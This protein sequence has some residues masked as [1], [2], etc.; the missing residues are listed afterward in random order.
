MINICLLKNNQ[1]LHQFRSLFYSVVLILIF[2]QCTTFKKETQL[3]EKPNI[4][5]IAVDDL[6]P[7]LN[8]FGEDHM[9]SPNIDQLAQE[10]VIFTRAYCN[11]P[12][13]GASRA[14]LL[15]GTRPTRNRFI[16]Y[17]SSAEEE[18]SEAVTLPE[19][20]RD[21]GYYTISNGKIFH[22]TTDSKDSWDEIWFPKSN[23]GEV[24]NYL[25]PENVSI[26]ATGKR[27]Y[28]YEKAYVNDSAYF[29]GKIAN[30]AIQD[31]RKLQ[32][33]DKPFF[34][35][36]GFMKPHLPFNAPAKYWEMY[37]RQKISLPD[38]YRDSAGAP[39]QAI[40]NSGELRRYYGVPASGPVSDSMAI[41]LIHGYYASVSYMDAQVGRVLAALE[42]L[43]L[44]EN[45]LVILWGDHG[46]NLGEH[47]LWAKHCNFNSSLRAPLVMAGPGV[48]KNKKLNHVVEF[49]DIFP[50]LLE[51]A[52]LPSLADQLE[53]T[54][55]VPILNDDA[56]TWDN[57]AISKY[58][59]GISIKTDR[60]LYTEWSKSDS[61]IDARMLF[62]H[63]ND[64]KEKHNIAE[65]PENQAL[66]KE[67]QQKLHHSWGKD[68]N[69]ERAVVE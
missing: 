61:A 3:K 55:M 37:D 53:G 9:V 17:Y 14:S 51:M 29:D 69:K 4:L 12:V 58:N 2:S 52:E 34:L 26:A 11:I 27:G 45:T 24:G 13:C 59:N 6:R 63:Q 56:A 65:I 33:G 1:I 25:N 28:P 68:F 30:K 21:N 7:E 40:H 18:Y 36:V 5:F 42:T 62:D 60:Y 19:H 23:T 10:G 15:T 67:L 50:T 22:H 32:E 20:F 16:S 54:S 43:G 46:Y 44:K 47:T 48:P 8:S 35:A 66:V 41:S 64:L 31:L 38:T 57:Q 39:Q 49:V